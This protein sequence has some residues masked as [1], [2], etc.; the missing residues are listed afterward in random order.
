MLIRYMW[1]HVMLHNLG[2]GHRIHQDIDRNRM[3]SI[4]DCGETWVYI[5]QAE[6]N[7]TC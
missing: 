4:C 1:W 7:R 5:G 6:R 3:V 2:R